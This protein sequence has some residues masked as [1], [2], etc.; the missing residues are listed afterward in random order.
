MTWAM[1]PL[2]GIQ[3]PWTW[4]L[5]GVVVVIIALGAV[6]LEK[7]WKEA[8]ASKARQRRSRA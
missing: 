6:L 7:Y 8:P 3:P 4:V 2:F 5:M 1:A